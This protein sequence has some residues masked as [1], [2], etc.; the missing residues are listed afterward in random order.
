MKRGARHNIYVLRPCIK[1][2][3]PDRYLDGLCF[4]C[5][6]EDQRIKVEPRIK[7][8]SRKKAVKK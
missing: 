8:H 1:C 7:R 2:G 5:R 3:I 4:V 6:R